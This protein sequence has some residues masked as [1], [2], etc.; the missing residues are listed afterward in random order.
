MVNRE[1]IVEILKS[2]LN[3]VYC[4]TCEGN[5]DVSY[6]EDCHRKSMNW[7][8]STETAEEIADAI[9]GE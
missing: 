9:L 7:G 1:K 3:S 4:D 8:I 5:L 2:Y 6:C